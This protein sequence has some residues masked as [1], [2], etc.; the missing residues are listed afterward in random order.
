[1]NN[2][3]FDDLYLDEKII[4]YLN[5]KG[6]LKNDIG[7]ICYK[8]V[9]KNAIYKLIEYSNSK[10]DGKMHGSLISSMCLL[11][12]E[13]Y[14]EVYEY[15]ISKKIFNIDSIEELHALIRKALPKNSRDFNSE[16]YMMK[17]N[18]LAYS[19]LGEIKKE[20]GTYILKENSS[21]ENDD[22]DDEIISILEEYGF[23]KNNLGTFCYKEVIK[24]VVN[25]MMLNID[26]HIALGERL[27]EDT[28]RFYSYFYINLWSIIATTKKIKKLELESG[29]EGF[30]F[31]FTYMQR[32]IKEVICNSDLALK[33]NGCNYSEVLSDNI[34]EIAITVVDKLKKGDF[35]KS[36]IVRKL[37]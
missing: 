17:A 32:I 35:K 9:I 8:E 2:L 34:N 5:E 3:V 20:K 11:D 12:S 25:C 6:L 29:N 28:C 27:K 21:N 13:F 4:T 15:L 33:F 18:A 37:T 16:T 36:N 26:N 19:I 22:L 14:K 10:D 7:T 30:E 24:E 31:S 23:D 1:M